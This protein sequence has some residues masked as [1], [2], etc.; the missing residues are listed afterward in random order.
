MVAFYLKKVTGPL[1]DWFDIFS[2]FKKYLN[3]SEEMLRKTIIN[4]SKY[5]FP[6]LSILFINASVADLNFFH[7]I[8]RA[9]LHLIRIFYSFHAFLFGTNH[10]LK[11]QSR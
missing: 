2:T 1:I 7:G 3:D 8:Q 5:T 11:H 10:I 9:S 6:S 4:F